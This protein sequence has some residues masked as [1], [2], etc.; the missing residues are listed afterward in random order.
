[1]LILI[2]EM[3]R[4][5]QEIEQ[6]C[7]QEGEE[8]VAEKT[9]ETLEALRLAIDHKESE[10]AEKWNP[11]SLTEELQKNMA[12]LGKVVTKEKFTLSKHNDTKV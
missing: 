3:D 1:M 9:Q 8:T 10:G 6:L 5:T 7:Q 2:E 4:T 12:D 11:L